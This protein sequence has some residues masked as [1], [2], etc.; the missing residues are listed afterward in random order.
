VEASLAAVVDVE[1]MA[2]MKATVVDAAVDEAASLT[3]LSM[4]IRKRR[5]RRRR[6][7]RWVEA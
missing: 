2:D 4:E 7:M 1:D 5:K 6:I 3:S